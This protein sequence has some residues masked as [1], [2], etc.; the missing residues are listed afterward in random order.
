MTTDQI[1]VLTVLT[2]T[3]VLLGM[4]TYAGLMEYH[5]AQARVTRRQIAYA[6]QPFHTIFR[7]GHVCLTRGFFFLIGAICIGYV[8]YR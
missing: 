6:R 2:P 8:L 1:L 7:L 3:T 5:F 4:R